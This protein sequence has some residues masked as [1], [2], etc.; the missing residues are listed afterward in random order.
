[1]PFT[2]A[3]PVHSEQVIKKSR[4]IGCVEPVTG[5]E[6]AIAR[7]SELRAEHPAARHVCWAL[8][9]GGHSATTANRAGRRAVRCW[10]C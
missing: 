10:M 4:F 9:A 8:M 7:V 3:T 2:L 1:M 5:R 6:Q